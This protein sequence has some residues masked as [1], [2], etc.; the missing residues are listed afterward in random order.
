[1]G[2]RAYARGATL[3]GRRRAAVRSRSRRCEERAGYA[4]GS[5]AS[6]VE[7]ARKRSLLVFK[8]PIVG[9][10]LEGLVSNYEP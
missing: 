3:R 8:I 2:F 10:F 1:M 6:D 4:R 5:D 9:F 7:K